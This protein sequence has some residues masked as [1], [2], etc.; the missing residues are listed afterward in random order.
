[1]YRI[2]ELA[3]IVLEQCA[4]GGTHASMSQSPRLHF[5]S[6]LEFDQFRVSNTYRKIDWYKAHGYDPLFPK[7]ITLSALE[8]GEDLDALLSLVESEY[9][10]EFYEAMAG[11]IRQQWQ[12]FQDNW[13]RSCVS[14]QLSQLLPTYEVK[15]TRYGTAGSYIYPDTIVMNVAEHAERN[16]ASVIMHEIIHL[17]IEPYVQKY[18]I[19]HWQKERV[20]DLLFRSFFPEKAFLQ[21]LPEEAYV[22]DHIFDAGFADIETLM[23]KL[24]DAGVRPT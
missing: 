16:R 15:L 5:N 4:R 8:D 17:C 11:E 12:W 1:M 7:G 18:D 13:L 21:V 23:I 2:T 24:G 6:S 9:D 10:G 3:S 20:V 22:V 14:K 19:P